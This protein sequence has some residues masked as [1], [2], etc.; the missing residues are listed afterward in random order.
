MPLK[1]C[2][3]VI[4]GDVERGF[5]LRLLI[6]SAKNRTERYSICYPGKSRS[7]DSKNQGGE[8]NKEKKVGN[9]TQNTWFFSHSSGKC[10]EAEVEKR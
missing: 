10:G 7:G 4:Q 9:N 8:Q 5:L 6:G 3:K 1:T 2:I